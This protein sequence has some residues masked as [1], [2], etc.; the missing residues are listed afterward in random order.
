MG[1]S[2]LF[3]S[4]QLG[5]APR[6]EFSVT[7]KRRSAYPSLQQISKRP[8]DFSLY[9]RT[10][11]PMKVESPTPSGELHVVR[12]WGV[13]HVKE[14]IQAKLFTD[15]SGNYKRHAHERAIQKHE[16]QVWEGGCEPGV[17]SPL[18]MY[19]SGYYITYAYLLGKSRHLGVSNTVRRAARLHDSALFHLWGFHHNPKPR[20]NLAP[21]S[22]YLISPPELFSEVKKLREKLI[23]ELVQEG[24]D[25]SRHDYNYQQHCERLRQNPTS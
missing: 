20:F 23:A 5:F 21:G 24:T 25:I 1:G 19:R 15:A 13:S 3:G 6:K 9:L 17:K 14:K 8:L 11:T 12:Y 18:E 10:F 4:G 16:A 7:P 2:F 22:Q